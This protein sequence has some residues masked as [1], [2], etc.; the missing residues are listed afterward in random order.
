MEEGRS[1]MGTRK[2][3]TRACKQN[4]LLE[5]GLGST[6]VIQVFLFVFQYAMAELLEPKL[7]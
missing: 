2:F 3:L 7:I 6:S 1:V 4:L 5:S